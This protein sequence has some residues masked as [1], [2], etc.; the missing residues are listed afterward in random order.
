MRNLLATRPVVLQLLRFVAIGAINTA[1]DFIL[2]NFITKLYNVSAGSEL[3]ML[4]AL[5]F[6]VAIIQ[7]YLWNR[8]WAFQKN[9]SGNWQNAVRLTAV[10]GLGFSA[11]IAVVWGAAT[12]ASPI[13]FLIV[14]ALFLLLEYMLWR[15]F[16][17]RLSGTSNSGTGQFFSFVVISVI[18]LLINSFLVSVVSVALTPGLGHYVNPDTVKNLAKAIATIASLMWNFLGYKLVVFRK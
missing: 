7:S 6:S 13:Y 15:Q 14:L 1:L 10:G 4:N 18:G 2:L 11:F 5:G 12:G 3:G 16:G 17:L 8:A 9:T